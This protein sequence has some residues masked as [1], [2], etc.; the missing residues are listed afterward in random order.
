MAVQGCRSGVGY[1][2]ISY[3]AGG[4]SYDEVEEVVLIHYSRGGEQG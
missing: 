2:G 3:D 1:P 4:F